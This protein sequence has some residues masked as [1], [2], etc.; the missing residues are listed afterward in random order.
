MICH[1][2]INSKLSVIKMP[3]T[4][5]DV[6]FDMVAERIAYYWFRNP[7]RGASLRDV[8]VRYVMT[9]VLGY[10]LNPNDW[11]IY[12]C[13]THSHEISEKYM[14]MTEIFSKD[15][16]ELDRIDKFTRKFLS[17]KDPLEFYKICHWCGATGIKHYNAACH[18][19]CYD[20]LFDKQESG[21]DA[22]CHYQETFKMCPECDYM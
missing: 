10:P 13:L 1:I 17:G 7:D 18:S 11:T 12:D 16:D 6:V 3:D 22:C 14:R 15:A 8:K 20:F 19:R 5:V 9:D 4:N 2:I 21:S